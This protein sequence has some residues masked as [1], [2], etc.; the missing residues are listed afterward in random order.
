M[1]MKKNNEE[2]KFEEQSLNGITLRVYESGFASIKVSHDAGDIIING[3][4]RESKG[5]KFFAFPSHKYE[6]N[7]VNDVYVIGDDLK[8]I[9]ESL[10]DSIVE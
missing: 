10:V 4:I 1:K 9:I 7:Y 8:H 3:F 2:K 5:H 6:D